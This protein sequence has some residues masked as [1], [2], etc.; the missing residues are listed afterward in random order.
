MTA[1]RSTTPGVEWTREACSA[2][3]YDASEPCPWCA[4]DI[5]VGAK[6]TRILANGAPFAVL[7]R[8]CDEDQAEHERNFG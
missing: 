5:E 1:D 2:L 6:V 8:N 3:D 4:G 7:H